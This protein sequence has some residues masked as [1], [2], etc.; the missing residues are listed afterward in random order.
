MK[1]CRKKVLIKA[2]MTGIIAATVAGAISGC[3]AFGKASK[4]TKIKKGAKRALKTVE[5]YIDSIM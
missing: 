5:H 3:G 1:D 2:A 4:S